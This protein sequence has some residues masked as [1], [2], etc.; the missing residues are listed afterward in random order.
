MISIHTSLTGSD[1]R[2]HGLYRQRRNFNP[3]FPHGKWPGKSKNKVSV[4]WFQSTL[5]SR[6]VTMGRTNPSFAFLIS[7]HTS[8]TGSDYHSSHWGRQKNISIH[9]SLTGSDP[10]NLYSLSSDGISIHTSLTGSDDVTDWYGQTCV[11][12][13]STLPSREVTFSGRGLPRTTGF[14]STLPS[15]EVTLLLHL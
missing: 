10:S 14:Q 9:T 2:P 11:R 5:P 3:H 1:G 12:F 13:Q 4:T 7:I 8:L 15:R 6:E